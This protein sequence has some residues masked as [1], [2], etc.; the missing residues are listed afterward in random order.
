MVSGRLGRRLPVRRELVLEILR[1]CMQGRC[2]PNHQQQPFPQQSALT[3][4][5]DNPSIFTN[6]LLGV[7]DSQYELIM[8]LFCQ[9]NYIIQQIR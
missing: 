7:I 8:R 2:S 9:Q 4:Q 5:G 3:I 6:Q 1:P